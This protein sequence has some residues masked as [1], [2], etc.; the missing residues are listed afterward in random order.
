[1]DEKSS[2]FLSR[3]YAAVMEMLQMHQR[4]LDALTEKL[5][6][7]RYLDQKEIAEIWRNYKDVAKQSN[8]AIAA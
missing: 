4:F 2:I 3:Q 8:Q 1:M 5:L 6:Q 7:E